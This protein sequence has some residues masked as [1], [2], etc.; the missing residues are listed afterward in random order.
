VQVEINNIKI[1]YIEKG[2]NTK[3]CIILLHGW[4]ASIAAFNPIIENLSQKIKV[5]A[6]DF[7]GFGLSGS[8]DE[9]YHVEDYSKIVLEFI[10]L[11]NLDKV[12]LLGHSF[13]GRVIIKLVGK[14]GFK[15]QKVILVDSAGIRPKK[16]FKVKLKEK[17]F[18]ILKK[19][20]NVLLGKKNAKKVIDK[21]INKFGSSDYQNANDTMKEVFKNV[22][23]EDLTEYLPNINVPTL[24]IWGD[25]D[26]ETPIS[27]AI[28]MEELIPNAGLVTIEGA[29]HFSYLD[30]I[31]YFL[32]VL[33]KFLEGCD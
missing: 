15:P 27:D 6:I 25:K 22:I 9:S 18:K 7:P 33:N 19:I 8:P 2:P 24:L 10:K 16:T 20:T 12:I 31:N 3:T 32:I 29:G 28:K 13:G 14:L 5:Y 11:N 21:Y 23:N 4:G 26:M 30:N 17:I 1:N